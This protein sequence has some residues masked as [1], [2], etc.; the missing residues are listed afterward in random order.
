MSSFSLIHVSCRRLNVSRK[1]LNSPSTVS[2]S[3]LRAT[4]SLHEIVEKYFLKFQLHSRR[5]KS[6]VFPPLNV[7]FLGHQFALDGEIIFF[8]QIV[9]G[10]QVVVF[11]SLSFQF[12]FRF[13]AKQFIIINGESSCW[14]R[15]WH[16]LTG[17]TNIL[18]NLDLGTTFW[19]IKW[20][21][22][23]RKTNNLIEFDLKQPKFWKKRTNLTLKKQIS[24]HF[25]TF[26]YLKTGKLWTGKSKNRI[27]PNFEQKKTKFWKRLT[28]FTLKNKK[29]QKCSHFWPRKPKSK[30]QTKI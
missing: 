13:Y 7:F 1:V 24:Q 30:N 27:L 15:K 16:I 17:K 28:F 26:F 12:Q 5:L 14:H 11:A 10:R 29:F 3:F 2:F 19:P 21:F 23:T 20:T 22:L 18:T 9:L 4:Y 8:E 6:E 25:D